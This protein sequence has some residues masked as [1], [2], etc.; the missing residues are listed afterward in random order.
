MDEYKQLRDSLNRAPNLR[1]SAQNPAPQQPQAGAIVPA[2]HIHEVQQ[3]QQP[4]KDEPVHAKD[5]DT[6]SRVMWE[7]VVLTVST[8]KQIYVRLG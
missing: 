4:Q 1:Q 2:S 5:Q 6:E 7:F 8:N 3:A